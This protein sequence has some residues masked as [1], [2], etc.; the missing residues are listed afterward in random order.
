MKGSAGSGDNFDVCVIGGGINGAG[1][2]RDAAG[3]GLRVL[4]IEQGDLGQATSS[5]STKLIHGGLRY[6][7][8]YEFRL[9][10]DSLK[11]REVLLRIAPHLIHPMTFVL[12]LQGEIRPAWMI[13]AGLFLY[14][15]LGGRHSLP[16]SRAVDLSRTPDLEFP[17][18]RG[19][20]YADC[21]ADDARLVVLNAMSARDHGATI[22]IRTRCEQ[23]SPAG[24]G[25]NVT[26]RKEG[27]TDTFGLHARLIVNATGPWV[28]SF[29]QQQGLQQPETPQVRLVQGSHLIVPRLYDG[30]HAYLL[31]QPD[32][33]VVFAIPYERKYTLIGTTETAYSG[34]PLAAT[35]T[36]AEKTY[37]LAAA[38]QAFRK[39][40][41]ASDIVSTYSGVRPL[42]D[43]HHQ[44]A[45][46]VT[47]DYRLH[48]SRHGD[49]W[50][51][52]VFGGKL[53]TYRKLSEQVGARLMQTL[54]RPSSSWTDREPLPGG[55]FSGLD[56]TDFL[57]KKRQEWPALE[58]EL[59]LRY[60]RQ[61]GTCMDEILLAESGRDFGA[62]VCEAELRYLVAREFATTAE[63]ILW[64]R[65]KLG[66]HLPAEVRMRIERAVPDIVAEARLHDLA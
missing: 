29:L 62:G 51:L 2:A 20:T 45:R 27:Q 43:D 12:P 36:E 44:E 52:S 56:F 7:E 9:V 31:Q 21:W 14:D 18:G 58:P 13:R 8:Y 54:G 17:A 25:W 38:N 30:D 3:R 16:S 57:R 40:T 6:L 37:L 19:F 53:T 63:D 4:L 64:R 49:A 15:H 50:M 60:A 33:R 26:L 22:L 24:E 34:D 55:D 39:K 47:R 10:R 66:L 11:E 59:L 1:I 32:R 35:L 42:F 65:S 48:E 28:G 41:A 5:A 23:V 61:Y 46:A